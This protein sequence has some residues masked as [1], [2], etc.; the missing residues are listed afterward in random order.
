[1]TET[2]AIADLHQHLEREHGRTLDILGALRSFEQLHAL[3]H[4]EETR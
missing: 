4:E 2:Q 3:L 1:M